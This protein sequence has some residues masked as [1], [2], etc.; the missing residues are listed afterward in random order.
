LSFLWQ[1]KW[2]LPSYGKFY[3]VL[4]VHLDIIM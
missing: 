1:W 4:T 3:V 2:N